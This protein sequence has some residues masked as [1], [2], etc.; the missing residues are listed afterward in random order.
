MKTLTTRTWLIFAGIALILIPDIVFAP[1]VFFHGEQ[2]ISVD[3]L[4]G[5][6]LSCSMKKGVLVIRA[7]APG[8]DITILPAPDSSVPETEASSRP[9][10]ETIAFGQGA[11]KDKKDSPTPAPVREAIA[12]K[13][14]NLEWEAAKVSMFIEKANADIQ[15]AAQEQQQLPEKQAELNSLASQINLATASAAKDSGVDPTKWHLN[16][17][18]MQWNPGPSPVPPPAVAPVVPKKP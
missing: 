17:D 2:V 14:R 9:A 10:L 6:T 18:T 12:L 7:T 5:P 4:P 15:A 1:R 8:D 3:C 13:I 16:G 11:Q